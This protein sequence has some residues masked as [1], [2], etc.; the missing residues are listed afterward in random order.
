[1]L[2]KMKIEK[3]IEKI[4]KAPE[5]CRLCGSFDSQFAFKLKVLG[6]NE[7]SY[8]KCH[9][10]FSLQTEK[11]YWLS[12]AYETNSLSSLDTGVVQRNLNNMVVT[13]LVSKIFN[14]HNILDFGGGDGLLCRC[15]RDLNL[16]CYSSDRYAEAKYSQGYTQPNFAVPDLVLA[17]E[18]VEHFS[19]PSIE[20][21]E[22]LKLDSRVVLIST[23]IY[24][25]QD[26][27]WWYLSPENGQ[28][29]FF[30]SEKGLLTIANKYRYTIIIKGEY[31]IFT[32]KISLLKKIFTKLI[33]NRIFLRF[34]KLLV[35]ML[36][37]T[38]VLIDHRNQLNIINNRH[39]TGSKKL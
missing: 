12:E 2:F 35:L 17:Y 13:Y 39:A 31:I 21:E 34:A 27:N 23:Q 5:K 38:G 1:M 9:Q 36:P 37:T 15:L 11:P 26:Q 16:N 14:L 28:H 33:L 32:K 18:V 22:L 25:D 20:F 30:Y 8:F 6:S 7:V 10:C 24:F 19:N 4:K 3:S 29:I